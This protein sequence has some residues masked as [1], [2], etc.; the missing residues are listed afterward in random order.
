MYPWCLADGYDGSSYAAVSSK[1]SLSQLTLIFRSRP[2]WS[3]LSVALIQTTTPRSMLRSSEGVDDR[4][5]RF[6]SDLGVLHRLEV[7][8][9]LML[10]TVLPA[11]LPHS[12]CPLSLCVWYAHR[13]NRMSMG[14]VGA[15][16]RRYSTFRSTEPSS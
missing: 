16:M 2:S 5:R 11:C 13:I 14:Y 7:S 6:G 4:V 3:E 8:G 12:S 1:F 9:E 10:S 15:L